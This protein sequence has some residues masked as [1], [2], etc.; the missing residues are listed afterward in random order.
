MAVAV[1]EA[2]PD[3]RGVIAA[4]L[5]DYLQE[6]AGHREVAVGASDPRSYP[7]LDAYFAQPG[8]HA[9]LIHFEYVAFSVTSLPQTTPRD[10]GE[11]LVWRGGPGPTGRASTPRVPTAAFP[12]PY[13]P[14]LPYYPR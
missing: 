2:T 7:A 10:A 11:G 3:Q 5:D 13:P 9:F 6:L 1:G 8:R 12:C 14:R 4:L